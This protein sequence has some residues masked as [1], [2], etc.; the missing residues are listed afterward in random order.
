[1]THAST[2]ERAPTSRYTHESGLSGY[3]SDDHG[4][5][6]HEQGCERYINCGWPFGLRSAEHATRFRQAAYERARLPPPPPPDAPHV[7]RVLTFMTA[8]QGETVVNEARVTSAHCVLDT[9]PICLQ[10]VPHC[11]F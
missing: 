5:L 2:N 11:V 10:A 9:Q 4:D 3:L 8:A 6:W 7:P 1:M